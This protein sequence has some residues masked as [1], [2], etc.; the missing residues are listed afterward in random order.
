MT[1]KT[2]TESWFSSRPYTGGRKTK[3]RL[4]APYPLV[5]LENK[6]CKYGPQTTHLLIDIGLL[7]EILLITTEQLLINS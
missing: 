7:N 3:N 6:P 4:N 1:L 5:P 2:I